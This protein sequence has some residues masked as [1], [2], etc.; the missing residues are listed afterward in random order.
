M[1]TQNASF[2]VPARLPE[3]ALHICTVQEPTLNAETATV[4]M[5]FVPY[6]PEY[7]IMLI[8]TRSVLRILLF[9]RPKASH[10]SAAVVPEAVVMIPVCVFN[11]TPVCGRDKIHMHVRCAIYILGRRIARQTNQFKASKVNATHTCKLVA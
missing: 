7:A 4:G 5:P 1:S 10:A 3:P 6:V 9:D 2:S 8:C 11:V